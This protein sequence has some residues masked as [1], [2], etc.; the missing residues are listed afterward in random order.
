MTDRLFVAIWPDPAS[1]AVL[2]GAVAQARSA[3]PDLR[4]Q[5]EERWHLTLAFLGEADERRARDR[6]D[7]LMTGR[8]TG[9]AAGPGTT[10]GPPHAPG[11][12]YGPDAAHDSRA[13]QAGP[14]PE[15]PQAGSAGH[16][17]P[18]GRPVH[19]RA[20][21]AAHPLHLAGAGAF[22]PIVWVG[23][24]HG[25]WLTQ[26]AETVQR[27]LRVA[28]RRFRAHVTVG[29]ARGRPGP[30]KARAREVVP[31]LG[32]VRGPAWTPDWLTLVR[33]RTGPEPEYSILERWALP[34]GGR[35][36]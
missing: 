4:W 10:P 5:P 22:G 33:S 19:H 29:R 31:A 16:A 26:L 34:A 21:P 8:T 7:R 25:P 30:A 36:A 11:T 24:E 9:R 14:A 35:P 1:L 18:A 13:P 27:T 28:D 32:T 17:A 12:G 2:R 6:L 23:V 20:V 15:A 3:F